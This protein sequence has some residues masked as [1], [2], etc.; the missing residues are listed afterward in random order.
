MQQTVVVATDSAGPRDLII[1]GL[2]GVI[3]REAEF[4]KA[5][6]ELIHAWAVDRRQVHAIGEYAAR[7]V[8]ARFSV[9]AISATWA[10]LIDKS[11]S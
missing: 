8:E 2:T 3:L 1:N 6:T 5:T 11:F 7:A 10:C 9:A 4:V